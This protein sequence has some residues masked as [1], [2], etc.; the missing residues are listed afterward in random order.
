M[1]FPRQEY[2]NEL[3]FPSPRALSNSG[4]HSAFP[5]LIGRVFTTEPPGNPS[6]YIKVY[7]IIEMYGL[8]ILQFYMSV[9][10]Q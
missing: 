9:I 7:Q 10:P 4:I 6:Q 1:G 3:T 5:A 2:W 8:N